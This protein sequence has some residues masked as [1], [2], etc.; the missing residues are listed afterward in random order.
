MALL[1]FCGTCHMRKFVPL[2]HWQ[3]LDSGDYLR[4][5][6]GYRK[7][8]GILELSWSTKSVL[9]K[10][11]TITDVQ[12]HTKCLDAYNYLMNEPHSS[13]SDFVNRRDNLTS[14][15]KKFNVYDRAQNQ[16]VECCLWP[17]LYPTQELCETS[18]SGKTSRLSTKVSFMYKAQCSIAD[19]ATNYELLHFQYDMWLFKTTHGALTSG[20]FRMCSPARSLETKP[21]SVEYWKWQHR[22]VVDAV[23]QFGSPS[24]FLTISP[25]EWSFPVPPWLSSLRNLTGKGPMQLAAYETIH[26]TH[27][28]EQIIRG[29]L[30]G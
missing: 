13:Y 6:N 7:K 28:L 4:T 25:Y 24:V 5:E 29:Y 27:V 20:R 1:T 26:I 9:E 22:F 10:T 8:D 21:F 17:N 11:P 23:N 3:T 14:T 12:S 2:G 30:C 19:Y 16:Y 18:I 15:K